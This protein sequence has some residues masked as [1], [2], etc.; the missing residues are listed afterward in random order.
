MIYQGL[1]KYL[2]AR[3]LEIVVNYFTVTESTFDVR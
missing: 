2:E 1:N 3:S